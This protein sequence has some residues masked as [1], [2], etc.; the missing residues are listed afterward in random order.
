M[1]HLSRARIGALL[2]IA[3]LVVSLASTAGADDLTAD[4]AAPQSDPYVLTEP[5]PQQTVS[6]TLN[7][8][9]TDGHT[10]CNLENEQNEPGHYLDASVTSAD[11][12]VATVSPSSLHFTA[13]GPDAAQSFVITGVGNGGPIAVTIAAEEWR[14]AGGHNAV[15]TTDIVWVSVSGFGDG[16][17]ITVCGRPAAP[18]W[19]AHIL[20]GVKKTA[21]PK[22]NYISAVAQKMEPGATFRDVNGT[23]LAKTTQPAYALAVRDYLRTFTG[24]EGVNLPTGWPPNDCSTNGTA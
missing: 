19:A 7:S 13:C 24:L 14:A 9:D 10:G 23:L 22:A 4:P 8:V 18:A 11:D 1:L 21:G 20:K 6:V 3:G 12:L 16:G 2:L 17:E 15:F 5:N